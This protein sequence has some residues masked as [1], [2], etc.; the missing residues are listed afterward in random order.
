MYYSILF[1]YKDDSFRYVYDN[2]HFSFGLNLHDNRT[3]EE[4]D[5]QCTECAYSILDVTGLL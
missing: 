4:F 2:N 3:L 1:Q 5:T